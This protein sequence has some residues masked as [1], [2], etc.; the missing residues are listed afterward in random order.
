MHSTEHVNTNTPIEDSYPITSL[1][2]GMLFHSAFAGMA[3]TYQDVCSIM[4]SGPF[5]LRCIKCALERLS[6]N[7]AILRTA[8][9][10]EPT[11]LQ[12]VYRKASVECTSLVLTD[13]SPAAQNAA[14]DEWRRIEQ[15]RRFEWEKPPLLRVTV[16]KMGNNQH[17]LGLT[18]HHAILDGW[19]VS[20]LISDL[21][22]AQ[23]RLLWGLK[24]DS[25]VPNTQ[26]SQFVG[27]EQDALK[28]PSARAFWEEQLVGLPRCRISRFGL[29]A[30]QPSDIRTLSDGLPT[31][32]L[33]DLHQ[34]AK[35]LRVAIKTIFLTAHAKT[36]G[37]LMGKDEI[38]T[39]VVCNG[40]PETEDA[41]RLL[42]LF[43]NVVPFRIRVGGRELHSLVREVGRREVDLQ[44]FRR[45]PIAAIDP[46][47]A[48]GAAF[49]VIFDYHQYRLYGFLAANCGLRVLCGDFH[50]RTS[51]PLMVNVIK[52]AI[53]ESCKLMLKYDK[54]VVSD[55]QV[56][57]YV[58][59]YRDTLSRMCEF[60][61]SATWREFPTNSQEVSQEIPPHD[62]YP[63]GSSIIDRILAA[64]ELHRCL[65]ALA[66]STREIK[67]GDIA[68][69][70]STFSL[71]LVAAGIAKGDCVALISDPSA[72][73]IIAVLAIWMV[74]GVL[75]VINPGLPAELM[76]ELSDECVCKLLVLSG[77]V[78][79]WSADVPSM[80]LGP[81]ILPG[82]VKVGARF[83]RAEAHTDVSAAYVMFTSGS[84]GRPKGVVISHS[85]LGSVTTAIAAR[86]Q[87]GPGDTFVMMTPLTFDISLVEFLAPLSSGA[88]V[89]IAERRASL[90]G[91]AF[92]SMLSES[93]ATVVQATPAR[94]QLLLDTGW[95]S[96]RCRKLLCGGEALNASLRDDL[97][98]MCD[99]LWNMYGPTETTIW[100]SMTKADSTR[101]FVDLG[102]SIGGAKFLVLGDQLKRVGRGHAGELLISGPT[103]ALGYLNQPELTADKFIDIRSETGASQRLYKT[104]DLVRELVA[105]AIEFV[106]RIDRQIKLNGIRV[107]PGEI[108]SALRKH[109]LVQEAWVLA[110]PDSR[111]V[112]QE[113]IGFVVLA[114]NAQIEMNDLRAYLASSLP[115]YLVPRAIIRVHEIPLSCH[116]KID[117]NALLG[118]YKERTRN[119]KGD[120]PENLDRVQAALLKIWQDTLG[121]DRIGINDDFFALG[122]SSLAA[123][124]M[125][126]KVSSTINV[127]VPVESVLSHTTI[128]SLAT[129]ISQ[130]TRPPDGYIVPLYNQASAKKLFLIHPLGGH[131]LCY[132]PLLRFL[133]PDLACFGIRAAG[134][135]VGESASSEIVE[136]A[137][138]YAL[139][140]RGVQPIGPYH[141]A[142]WCMGGPIA[143]EIAR[144]LVAVGAE[145]ASLT[146]IS[147]APH[148]EEERSESDA[149]RVLRHL[150]GREACNGVETPRKPQRR[151]LLAIL[152]RQARSGML[153]PDIQD[154]AD[155]ERLFEVYDRH[156]HALRT[157][158]PVE[159]SC[160]AVIV[161]PIEQKCET[162]FG[163]GW[164]G[165]LRSG[166]KAIRVPG[167]HDTIL[168]ENNVAAV[169]EVIASAVKGFGV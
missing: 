88:R 82:S 23:S 72:E 34:L 58:R 119:C 138:R 27:L 158:R 45:F 133:P 16:H 81:E 129:G 9:Q 147:A 146:I 144:E 38:V 121:I 124:R 159:I 59:H 74:G 43:I 54:T 107:E 70:A 127:A 68:A 135:K 29:H 19:S 130:I 94:W 32:L 117:S 28:S 148:F 78:Q 152:E 73:A 65:P 4:V 15:A 91:S 8:F 89:W 84:S 98:T 162:P 21:L 53:D 60:L 102:D 52:H 97:L 93:G 49:D 26:F 101:P 55:D 139:Y 76:R 143:F 112:S 77:A 6:M 136:M 105:G 75:V 161:V 128:K 10:L 50:E 87:L 157:Y 57:E 61:R 67:Y 99:E 167:T 165:F 153:R 95:Q 42:G 90:N 156:L 160:G 85:S 20:V 14:L 134:L 126:A 79:S 80:R 154:I 46:R 114:R 92:G 47:I 110:E 31:G 168:D 113:L 2:G 66:D 39:G 12:V 120:R 149:N 151:D 142:G 116:G 106:G 63:F 44:P 96:P 25:P 17:H 141:L 1:Q 18:F 123:L 64:A 24:D 40:R 100:A 155:A 163:L 13:H 22:R 132:G 33:G 109:S 5:D 3:A 122:G 36:L 37:D 69:A 164:S 169:A 30:A 86:L 166:I 131:L 41:D 7:H 104:G 137:K 62:A 51:F 125:I 11:P 35:E 111:G 118:M 115:R 145:V 108:E 103:L 140:I 83:A 56:A 71:R 150:F 48:A